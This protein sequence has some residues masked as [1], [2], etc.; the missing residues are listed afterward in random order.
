MQSRICFSQCHFEFSKQLWIQDVLTGVR[1]RLGK[2]N[3]SMCR[4]RICHDV[5]Q[6]KSVRIQLILDDVKHPRE[7]L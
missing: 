2:I 6:R 4:S 7:I 1:W 3:R 5:R